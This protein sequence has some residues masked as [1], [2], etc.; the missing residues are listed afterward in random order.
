MTSTLDR[1]AVQ[2]R[3][4][5]QEDPATGVFRCRRDI[6]TDPDLF[7]LEMKHIFEGVGSTWPMKARCPRSTI[8]TPPGLA[9]NRWSSPVTN[10]ARCTGWSTPVPTV[11]PCC[12]GA[13]R[14]T[15]AHSPAHS[16][17]GPSATPASCSRS[18]MRRPAL[19]RTAS[20]VTAP[21]TSSAW[22]ALKTTAVSCS[23]ASA[24]QC[25]N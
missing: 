21:M 4:S 25:R 3:E 5:V 18:R 19:I 24:R 2:L 8:T 13:N 15:R 1:L 16:M 23:A 7:A 12:A 14:A 17:A 9:A 20:T 6:F 10:R 11:A 22:A